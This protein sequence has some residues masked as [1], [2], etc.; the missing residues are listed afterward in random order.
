MLTVAEGEFVAVVGP[1]GC[2]KSTLLNVAAGLLAPSTGTGE[3]F[4]AWLSGIN[5]SPA[6]CS[7]PKA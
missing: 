1:T 6:A 4:G 3:V 7:R 5:T 2:G